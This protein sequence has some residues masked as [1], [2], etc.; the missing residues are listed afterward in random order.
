MP[1]AWSIRPE[2]PVPCESTALSLFP[3]TWLWVHSTLNVRS[4]KSLLSA[5]DGETSSNYIHR[6]ESSRKKSLEE[7]KTGLVSM[8]WKVP[9][10]VSPSVP[11]QI[12]SAIKRGTKVRLDI[13]TESTAALQKVKQE[14]STSTGPFSKPDQVEG[15]FQAVRKMQWKF[16]H[17]PFVWPKIKITSGRSKSVNDV[18]WKAGV[19]GGLLNWM[20][21]LTHSRC[22]E[23]L[24][25]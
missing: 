22:V 13:D 25:P 6:R 18:E 17:F 19:R 7:R 2:V 4:P 11:N 14:C 10:A 12:D 16:T 15:D 1:R 21:T 3:V 23:F 8:Q 5:T 24:P 9:K 20:W